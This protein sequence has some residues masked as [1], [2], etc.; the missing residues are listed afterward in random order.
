MDYAHINECSSRVEIRPL[1][2]E[3]LAKAVDA[4]RIW[5]KLLEGERIRWNSID[6]LL[7]LYKTANNLLFSPQQ[8][9]PMRVN[10]SHEGAEYSYKFALVPR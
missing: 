3:E 6:E 2:D 7:N 5:K 4:R 9:L 8:P 10:W 1:T